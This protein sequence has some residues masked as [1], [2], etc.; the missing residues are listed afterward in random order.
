VAKGIDKDFDF[1]YDYKRCIGQF[2]VGTIRK[3][4]N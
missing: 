3:T 4:I 1:G 2:E